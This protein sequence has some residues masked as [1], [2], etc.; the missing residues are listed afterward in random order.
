MHN[1]EHVNGG[2]PP[3]LRELL[4]PMSVG[5]FLRDYWGKKPL[6]VETAQSERFA[7]LF[8]MDRFRRAVS[9]HELVELRGSL[10]SGATYFSARGADI[11]T[12]L[13]GGATL[14]AD[15]LEQADVGLGACRD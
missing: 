8:D 1:E 2:R 13:K 11:D 7:A 5:E 14:C 4:H 3:G 12:L 10:D 9:K 6:F 15:H